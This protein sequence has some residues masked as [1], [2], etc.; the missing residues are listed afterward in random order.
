MGSTGTFADPLQAAPYAAPADAVRTALDNFRALLDDM[1]FD[2]ELGILGVG[3]LQLLRR[4]QMRMELG[5]VFMALWRLA[6]QRSFP[7]DAQR[8]FG[9]FLGDYGRD[10]DDAFHA[11][12]LGRAREYWE[13]LRPS[14]DADFSGVARHL[15]SFSDKGAGEDRSAHLRLALLLRKRYQFIFERL[16]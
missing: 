14:G 1:D 3:R 16:L 11:G 13:M 6:L 5:G 15:C 2:A 10:H 9:Q 12:M 8:M 7:Q 4:R